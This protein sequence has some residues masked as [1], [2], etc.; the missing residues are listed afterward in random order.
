MDP[1]IR[2][3]LQQI[4]VA[5]VTMQLFKKGIRNTAMRGV[6]PLNSPHNKIVGEAYTLRFIPGREDLI[7]LDKLASPQNAQRM[8]V[9]QATE[10]SILVVD[11]RGVPEIGV[12]GDILIERLRVR[13]VAGLVTD[14]GIRDLEECKGS[15]FSMYGAGAAAPASLA[16]HAPAETQCS[17]GCGGIAVV[18][19]DVIVGDGDGVVVIPVQLA[20]DVAKDGLEQERFERFAKMKVAG[21][22]SAHGTYPPNDETKAQYQEWVEA[23]EPAL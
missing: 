21:G 19:G 16:A 18:P 1:K 23:G 20:A 14:G 9:E 15:G 4:S 13:G 11:A 2:E 5:T 22:A 10:G 12:V 7:S 6:R 3:Q 17:I 8:A